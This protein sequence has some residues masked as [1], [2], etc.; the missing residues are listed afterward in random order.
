[1]LLAGQPK[2][3]IARDVEISDSARDLVHAN[4]HKATLHATN[5][6]DGLYATTQKILN[7]EG[8]PEFIGL[9]LARWYAKFAAGEDIWP[10]AH[11]ER[12]YSQV[13]AE[14]TITPEQRQNG[15]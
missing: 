3:L 2:P 1:M 10:G 12:I 11:L 9:A 4:V 13:V 14:R 7:N 15:R 8:D 6:R 5:T